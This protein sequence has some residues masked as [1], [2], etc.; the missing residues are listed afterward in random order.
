MSGAHDTER[1][2][3][4]LIRAFELARQGFGKVAP[5]PPVGAV[6]VREGE[7]VGE[8]HHALCGGPHAEVVA[9]SAAGDRARG[10]TLYVSLE[11]CV[12]QGR[13]GPCTE[14]VIAAGVSRVVCGVEDPNP[15][16]AGKGWRRLEQAGI[17]VSPSLLPEQGRALIAP[18]HSVHV[19]GRPYTVLKWAMSLDGKI[20]TRSG[21]SQWISGA[22]SRRVV[23]RLRNICQVVA[24][25]RGTAVADDPMLTVRDVPPELTVRQP[26][27]LIVD[28]GLQISRDSQLARS[29]GEVRTIVAHVGHRDAGQAGE[30]AAL[31][32]EPWALPDDPEGRVDLPSL[33]RRLA[34]QG[35][36]SILVEGGGEL[37]GGLADA[38]LV[39]AA[40]VFLAPK[41]IGG[42]EA[43]NPV[44]GR[45]AEHL[46]AALG[47]RF[48]QSVR[49]G[50][51]LFLLAAREVFWDALT[52]LCPEAV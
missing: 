34:E 43:P 4:F 33:W 19:Q 31:G 11:P 50:D 40:A 42:A 26:V 5:N 6:L 22:E 25:G 24:V 15:Q 20:A 7:I 16:V 38:G 12:H 29:A 47:L 17:V 45:G 49:C 36:Q 52:G 41:L 2:R 23:H 21:H 51:D 30:L 28:S 8:G 32:I 27:R 3:Q 10:A 1:D 37:G 18:F 39:D 13:T 46:D 48:R 44:Q 9:L 35:L 14:R